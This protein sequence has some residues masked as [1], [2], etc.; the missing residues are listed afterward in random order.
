[1]PGVNLITMIWVYAISRPSVSHRIGHRKMWLFIP[2][3]FRWIRLYCH[4]GA[5]CGRST[6]QYMQLCF[7]QVLTR[8]NMRS[9]N[10]A[11][12]Q[13]REG[14]RVTVVGVDR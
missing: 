11:C 1:M 10:A 6:T 12:D 9:S 5:E 3:E 13:R 2:M 8:V 4:S 14:G 7:R